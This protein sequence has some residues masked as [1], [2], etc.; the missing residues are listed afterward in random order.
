MFGLQLMLETFS[1]KREKEKKGRAREGKE[2]TRSR[3]HTQSERDRE[4]EGAYTPILLSWLPARFSLDILSKA[5]SASSPPST[6]LYAMEKCTSLVR[7]ATLPGML[8]NRFLASFRIWRLCG[9][10]G[11]WGFICAYGLVWAWARV[12]VW[13]GGCGR[14]GVCGV[15]CAQ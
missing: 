13:K 6:R 4:G 11:G 1:M 2:E 3:L 8:L 15:S 14:A 9:W 5:A 12:D 10:V 7:S